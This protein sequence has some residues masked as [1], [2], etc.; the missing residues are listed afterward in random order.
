MFPFSL[1]GCEI[2]L[3][4]GHLTEHTLKTLTK[5]LLIIVC[6]CTTEYNSY[7][8][9]AAQWLGNWAKKR[10]GVLGQAPVWAFSHCMCMGT[11]ILSHMTHLCGG[12]SSWKMMNTI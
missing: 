12:E 2:M 1:L 8:A 11:F 10:G 4:L 7:Q 3:I 9:V 5:Q 6:M